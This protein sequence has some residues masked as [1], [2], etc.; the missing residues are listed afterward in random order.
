MICHKKKSNI[1]E[2]QQK[3]NQSNNNNNKKALS[4]S[5][6]IGG[7][8]FWYSSSHQLCVYHA[9]GALVALQMECGSLWLA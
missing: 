4:Y 6:T 7:A 1:Q 2:Q 8:N 9:E 3:P 5:E